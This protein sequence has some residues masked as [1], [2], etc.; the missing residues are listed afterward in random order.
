[1]GC[2]LIVDDDKHLRRAKKDF[3]RRG[4]EVIETGAPRSGDIITKRRHRVRLHR[5]LYPRSQN[6]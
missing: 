1:M 4:L 3:V 2:V 5:C 6:A